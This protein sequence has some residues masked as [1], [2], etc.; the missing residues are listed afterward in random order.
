MLRNR[1]FTKL[2]IWRKKHFKKN[3]R[4]QC[5]LTYNTIDSIPVGTYVKVTRPYHRG[6]YCASHPF[7]VYFYSSLHRCGWTTG[8]CMVRWFLA[9]TPLSSFDEIFHSPLLSFPPA[10]SLLYF[11]IPLTPLH[12][13]IFAYYIPLPYHHFYLKVISFP[14]MAQH[15]NI[16]VKYVL[17]FIK[18]NV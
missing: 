2:N 4:H 10:P 17:I 11:P 18:P 5:S 14:P 9:I 16:R 7:K 1:K 6:M 15:S 12:H 3:I 13:I 8:I